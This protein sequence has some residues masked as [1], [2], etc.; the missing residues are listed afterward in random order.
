MQELGGNRLL[1]LGASRLA[2]S[3]VVITSWC[4]V[5][6]VELVFSIRFAGVML[7]ALANP[8]RQPRAARG[9]A[10]IDK[11]RAAAFASR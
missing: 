3:R 8:R 6:S 9:G 2:R 5:V 4:F 11:D 1:V 7:F 10:V